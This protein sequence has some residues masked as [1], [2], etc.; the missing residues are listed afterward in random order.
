M[1]IKKYRPKNRICN[2]ILLS[3]NEQHLETYQI[4]GQKGNK[5]GDAGKGGVAGLAGQAGSVK[6]LLK[7][8]REFS[9]GV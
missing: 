3:F 1:G 4:I 9:H 5:G 6:V 2:Q 7:D 8:N